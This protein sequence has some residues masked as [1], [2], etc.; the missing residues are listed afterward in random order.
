MDILRYL[1]AR[2]NITSD[3]GAALVEYAFLLALIALVCVLAV[4]VVG[5]RTNN[6]FDSII[7]S[8]W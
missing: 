8:P 3:R 6:K 2:L 1:Q 7:S 4:G 5:T